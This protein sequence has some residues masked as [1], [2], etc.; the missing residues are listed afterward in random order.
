M[1]IKEEEIA[2]KI[3]SILET[4]VS[5]LNYVAFDK[6]RTAIGDFRDHE[7]PAVQVWDVAQ[8][9]EHVRGRIQVTWS[10]SAEIINRSQQEGEV[11]QKGIWT[12]RHTIQKALWD[13]PNLGI[14]GVIHLRYTGNITDLHMV[15]PNYISR[16]DFDVLFY[17]DLT[18]SC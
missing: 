8:V 11:N 5:E 16:L 10:L 2:D 18:G 13:V 9:A 12:L 4:D 6:I 7:L 15:E 3:V 14:P 17:D 1:A